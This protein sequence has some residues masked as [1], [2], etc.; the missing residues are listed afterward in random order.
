M[1]PGHCRNKHRP[2]GKACVAAAAF[3]ALHYRAVDN[4]AH[5]Q[6]QCA[7][8]QVACK[9]APG[10]AWCTLVTTWPLAVGEQE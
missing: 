1:S 5:Q 3:P 4:A 10:G 6:V 9:A 7:I 2:A 8:G